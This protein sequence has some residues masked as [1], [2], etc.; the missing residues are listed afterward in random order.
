MARELRNGGCEV[1]VP[2]LLQVADAPPPFWPAVVDSVREPLQR[3]DPSRRIALVMHSNAGYFAPVIA[4]TS[5]HHVDAL[6]FVDAGLPAASGSTPLAP[7]EFIGF[8][9][10][11]AVDGILPPWTE[12]WDEEDV[13]ALFPDEQ[14][15]RAVVAEEPCLPLAYYEQTVPAP[16]GWE[17]RRCAF[18]Q[19]SAAYDDA[20]TEARRRGWPVAKVAGEHLHMLVDPVGSARAISELAK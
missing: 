2:S 1:M 15:R 3:V 17:Q 6:V 5:Q 11:K 16:P 13:A 18:L 8:L 12:W 19:F 14:T 7:P 20:A 9:R 4:E 10:E